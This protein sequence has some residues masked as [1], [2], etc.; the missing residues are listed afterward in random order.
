MNTT[1]AQQKAL[2]DALVALADCLE[3]EKCNMRLKT[4]IKSKEATFQVVLD[5]LALTPFYQAF[6][7]TAD[8]PA[9]YMKEFWAT[10]SVHKPSIRFA[11]NKKKVSLDVDIFREI[12]QFGPEIQE[13]EF[14]DLLLEQD[15]L[16]FIKDLRHTRDITYLTDIENKDAKKTNN[17]SYPRFTKIIIDYFMSKD[18]SISRRN[19][20]FWHTAR[21]DTMFTSMRCISRHENTQVYGTILSKELKN[22]AMLE[23]KAYQTYYAFASGEKAPKPKYIRKKANSDISSKK[24]LVQ[25]TKGTRLK[26][27][28]KVAKSDKKKQLAKMPK[29]KGLNVLSEVSLTESEQMKLATKRIKTQF[30]NSHASGLGDGVDTQ[31]KRVSTPP[32]YELTEEEEYKEDDDRDKEGEQEEEDEDDLYKDLNINLERSDVEMTDAQANQDTEDTHVTLTTV[33][34]VVQQQSSSVLSDLVSKF[35]NPSA[36]IGI[37]SILNQDTQSDTLVNIPVSAAAE[38]PSFAVSLI[39]GIVDTYLA[40]K[41]KEVVDV[42]AQPQ[43]NKLREEAQAE[44]QEF[45]NQIDSTIKAIIKEQVQAQVS[46][47]MPKIE[48]YVTDS[49]GAKVLVR[50]TNQ[51]QTS[52]VVAASLSEFDLEKILIDKM[53]TNKSIDRSDTQKN[54]YNALV[55]SYNIDKYIIT[56]YEFNTGNEGVSPVRE[57]LNEDVWHRNPSGPPTPDRE[58]H[59]TKTIDNRPPQPWIIQMAQAAG[60]QSSFNEFLATP[61]DFSAFIMHRLKI[62]NQTQKVLT[63]LTY[64]LIKV[65]CKSVVELEYHLEDV[66]KATNDRLDWHNLKGKPYPHDLSKPVPLILNEQSRQVIPLDHFI[67]ND[68]EYLKGGSSSKKY[69]TSITKTKAADYGQVKW[70]EDNLY[71]FRECDFKRL[72]RQDIEDMLLLLVQDKLTNLN[73]EERYQKKINLKNPDTYRSNLRRMTPYTAYPDI[74][75]IIYEDEMNK[76]RLMRTDELHKF[77]D[78]TLNHVQTALND[79]ALGIEMEYL[80]KRK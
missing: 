3:F 48:K 56:S 35:I 58:W 54:L 68:I 28:A 30:H 26:T 50:S 40:F 22:Q 20:M 79:I 76:N 31:S 43:T 65:T 11:I 80:P 64:D 16:S 55:E 2:E 39:S 74:Q 27:S 38:T 25:A 9:I 51:P 62:D 34:P 71:K 1:Q 66:F 67:N 41:M 14:E 45:L 59:K 69:T 63:G 12:L 4:D 21:D 72:R 5:T 73:L 78:G 6:P 23:S 13:Q 36:D 19:K 29:A 57:A 61:I 8:F 17:M 60:T 32:D 42:A 46:K 70:I 52:Y 7:I 15:I 77:S 75:G 49:L 33:P 47:I 37:D 18:Q 10:V 24:K 44:N 53:E